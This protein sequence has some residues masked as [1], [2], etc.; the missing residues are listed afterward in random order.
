MAERGIKALGMGSTGNP[1]SSSASRGCICSQEAAPWLVASVFIA[2]CLMTQ[3]D[4][5]ER[6]SRSLSVSTVFAAWYP[7]TDLMP[8]GM[9]SLPPGNTLPLPAVS[10]STGASGY[11]DSMDVL[12]SHT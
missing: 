1:G 4:D 5:P 8:R 2:V 12:G 11:M 10:R 6:R 9:S 7:V 3:G